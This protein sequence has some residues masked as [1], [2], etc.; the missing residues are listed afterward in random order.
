MT[1]LLAEIKA[2][3]DVSP[4]YALKTKKSVDALVAAGHAELN[5]GI[6][7]GNGA[8]AKFAVRLTEAGIAALNAAP[9]AEAKPAPTF[10]IFDAIELPGKTRNAASKY[11][12]DKLAVGQFIFVPADGDMKR[13]QTSLSSAATGA[14][15]R[16]GVKRYSTR[17]VQG[18]AAYGPFTAPSDGV[19]VVRIADKTAE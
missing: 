9:A 14:A 16:S 1:K 7:E 17:T 2:A 12:L 11:P 3:M 4:F 8:A 13:V 19:V 15:K 6:K 5:E 10:A 18:G